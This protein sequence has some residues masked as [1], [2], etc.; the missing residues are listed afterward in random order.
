MVQMLALDTAVDGTVDFV[1][2]SVLPGLDGVGGGEKT[3]GECR[4]LPLLPTAGSKDWLPSMVDAG[5]KEVNR[6]YGPFFCQPESPDSC[7]HNTV[8]Q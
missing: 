4:A 6:V 2:L 5:R 1:A 8:V 7:I 3:N